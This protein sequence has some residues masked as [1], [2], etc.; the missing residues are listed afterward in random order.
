[1]AVCPACGAESP[2][3]AKFCLECGAALAV[4]AAA[5]QERKIV[6]VLFCDVVGFTET[7]ELADPE[8]VRARMEAYYR[9]LRPVIESFGGSVEKFIGDAVMAVFGLPIAH[10]DDAAG[11][12]RS[13]S[14]FARGPNGQTEK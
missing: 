6:T 5:V 12:E 4:A 13:I 7:S 9:R 10:D 2:E 11:I 1:V 14:V 8:D 3:R